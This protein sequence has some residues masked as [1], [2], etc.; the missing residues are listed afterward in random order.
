MGL[1]DPTGAGVIHYI[2]ANYVVDIARRY[3][4]CHG[5]VT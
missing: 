2:L 3:V 4:L 5:D 1:I